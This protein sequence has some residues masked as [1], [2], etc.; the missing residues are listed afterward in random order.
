MTLEI[1]KS[2]DS[3]PNLS[4]LGLSAAF[5]KNEHYL[6]DTPFSWFSYFATSFSVSFS[7]SILFFCSTNVEGKDKEIGKERKQIQWCMMDLASPWESN[8]TDCFISQNHLPRVHMNDC[9]SKERKREEFICWLP[10]PIGQR[11]TPWALTPP[12]F[13]VNIYTGTE[14]VSINREYPGWKVTENWETGLCQVVPTKS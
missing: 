8:M 12:H 9:I 7:G 4:S 11:F 14:K 1:A 3:S 10:F 6:H 5:N 13:S 2:K